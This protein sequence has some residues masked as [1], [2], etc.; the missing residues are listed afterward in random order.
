VGGT[1]R[2]RKGSRLVEKKGVG[3]EPG[4]KPESLGPAVRRSR[5]PVRERL[6][7]VVAT[8]EQVEEVVSMDVHSDVAGGEASSTGAS[9]I[10][11]SRE[12]GSY[13]GESKETPPVEED[14]SRVDIL[15]Q[16]EE[17]VEREAEA[18]KEGEAKKSREKTQE[19]MLWLKDEDYEALVQKELTWHLEMEA[20]RGQSGK[21]FWAR[22]PCTK[23]GREEV[24]DVSSLRKWLECAGF[25]PTSKDHWEVLGVVAGGREDK[26]EVMRSER[27]ALVLLKAVK[28][29]QLEQEAR[30]VREDWLE[31]FKK[32]GVCC[33]EDIEGG[34]KTKKAGGIIPKFGELDKDTMRTI[35]KDVED[36]SSKVWATQFSQIMEDYIRDG[37]GNEL[38]KRNDI[39]DFVTRAIADPKHWRELPG[40]T[41]MMWPLDPANMGRIINSLTKQPKGGGRAKEIQILV[42]C[43]Q[44]WGC[45]TVEQI[46]DLWSSPWIGQKFV[47]VVKRIKILERPSEFVAVGQGPPKISRKNLAIITLAPHGELG[48]DVIW[49]E[50]C[51][52]EME[53]GDGI[54]IECRPEKGLST[55]RRLAGVKECLGGEFDPEEMVQGLGP[56]EGRMA[57]HI[58]AGEGVRTEMDLQAILRA[59][60]REVQDEEIYLA[61][62]SIFAD[63][64]AM[65]MESTH[66]AAVKMAWGLCDEMVSLGRNLSLVRTSMGKD[67]W[68]KRWKTGTS[69]TGGPA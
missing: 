27:A 10:E 13:V 32:A 33:L 68:E 46:K 65:I 28:A 12:G 4:R 31:R 53:C 64:S 15:K 66:S 45:D 3:E 50:R 1:S 14:N 42:P 51:V 36:L 62:D 63:P 8:K 37:A 56:E 7:G 54:R 69:K 24:K 48:R 11:G 58:S 61:T 22:Q 17:E 52:K 21:G 41:L 44:P 18:V 16:R 23:I 25:R 30:G 47:Q 5:S 60:R 6:K 34:V 29:E 19:E 57:L 55:R 39:E 9:R 20:V 40:D 38:W 35:L 2:R 26:V 59:I 49:R 43:Q 67:L